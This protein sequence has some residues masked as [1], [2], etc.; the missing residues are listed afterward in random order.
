MNEMF[1]NFICEY[2][3]GNFDSDGGKQLNIGVYS[4]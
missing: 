3:P 2:L 1:N 4:K